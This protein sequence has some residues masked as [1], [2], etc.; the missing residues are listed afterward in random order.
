M[1]SRPHEWPIDLV[2]DLSTWTRA[3]RPTPHS[4]VDAPQST[5]NL[6]LEIMYILYI[7]Y[8]TP[9]Q[10]VQAIQVSQNPFFS[11]DRFNTEVSDN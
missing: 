3:K 5:M 9:I 2:F 11:T 8:G 10:K 6:N 1:T 7:L 4:H